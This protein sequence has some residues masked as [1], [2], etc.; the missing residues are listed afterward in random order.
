MHIPFGD[1]PMTHEAPLHL[2]QAVEVDMA[3]IEN[4]QQVPAEPLAQ[5][6]QQHVQAL[7]AAFVAR[8]KE[9]HEVAGLLGMWAGTAL[10]HDLAIEHF[11]EPVDE[12]E[13]EDKAKSNDDGEED[14]E[15]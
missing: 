7:E 4:A 2:P 13:L 11:S 5:V 14:E 8:E 3:L 12:F 1:I 15:E 10:L 9:S 6:D